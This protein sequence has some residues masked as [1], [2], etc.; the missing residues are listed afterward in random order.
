MELELEVLL[1]VSSDDSFATL[2]LAVFRSALAHFERQTMTATYGP[3]FLKT[4]RV[5]RFCFEVDVGCRSRCLLLADADAARMAMLVVV[6]AVAAVV[7]DVVGGETISFE[8][9]RRSCCC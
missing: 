4:F 7:A 2:F 8:H 3:T 5:I 9:F 1:F 6:V